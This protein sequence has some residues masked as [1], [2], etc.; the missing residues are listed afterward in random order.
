VLRADGSEAY[1]L[2]GSVHVGRGAPPRFP[3]VVERAFA[4]ASALVLEV[5]PVSQV[6][7]R[8]RERLTQRYAVIPPPASLRD[9]V[10]SQVL[11]ALDAYLE[12]REEPLAPYLGFEPWA[13]VELLSDE[14]K[15]ARGLDPAYGVDRHFAER[16]AGR[17]PVEEL[18]SAEAQLRTLASLPPEIHELR[19]LEALR[20]PAEL[21][22][23][24]EAL[25]SAWEHGDD[26]EL[27]RLLF[28]P[29]RESPELRVFYERFIFRRNQRMARRLA[30]LAGD[31]RMRFAVIGVGHL[32]GPHGVPALLHARGFRIQKR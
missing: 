32:L 25:L 18:E 19:L 30:T 8:E 15:R 14:A 9:R 20:Q 29:L 27:E 11:V 17:M 10:S 31:G 24:A 5:D 7:L 13:L 16:A 22:A 2:L 12:E 6:S 1:Y 21:G 4:R 26:E 3:P 28:A 23:R